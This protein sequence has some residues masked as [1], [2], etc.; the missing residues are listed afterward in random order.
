MLLFCSRLRENVF[1]PTKF[2]FAFSSSA[3]LL[4]F[5]F[6]FVFVCHQ[7]WNLIFLYFCLLL[8][9]IMTLMPLLFGFYWLI[10]SGRN[11]IWIFSLSFCHEYGMCLWDPRF[12]LNRKPF[13][14]MCIKW[15]TTMRG[16]QIEV[17]RGLIENFFSFFLLRQKK[18]KSNGPYKK[19][20]KILGIEG[21]KIAR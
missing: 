14:S 3:S 20:V 17:G 8:V 7:I 6:A 13:R 19:T 1:S 15:M 5:H 16:A 9:T 12:L 11:K 21:C 18:K 2:L 10:F 4:F